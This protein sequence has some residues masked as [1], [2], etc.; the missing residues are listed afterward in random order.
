M[1][2][3]FLNESVSYHVD[4]VML[5]DDEEVS[6]FTDLINDGGQ[7]SWT[8]T[9][10]RLRSKLGSKGKLFGLYNDQDAV[11]VIGIKEAIVDGVT[12]GEIGYLYID[13]DYRS[14][15]NAIK[16]YNI[17][18]D[19]AH[20]FPFLMA[21]TVTSNRQVNT[22]LDKSSKMK[23]LFTIKSPYSSNMLNYWLAYD[24]SG[25]FT[26]DELEEMFHEHF[27][28]SLPS[29]ISGV[30]T[31]S[32]SMQNVSHAP[33]S[34]QKVL[35]QIADRSPLIKIDEYDEGDVRL[36]FGRREGLPTDANTVF[37]GNRFYSKERQ[38]SILRNVVPTVNTFLSADDVEGEF[39]AKR[40]IGQKQDGQLINQRPDNEEDYIFQPLLSINKEYRVV[41]YYMN[42][43]Y[44]VSGVYEKSGSNASFISI[45][46]G[47]VFARASQISI[48]AAKALGYGLS[49]VD[50]ALVE[51]SHHISEEIVGAAASTLG[52]IAGKFSRS[53]VGDNHVLVVLEANTMP[54]MSNP[55]IMHDLMKSILSN[56]R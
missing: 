16:L 4:E 10:D 45:T 23:K 47:E 32:V 18:L 36:M 31:E 19:N 46:G 40:N 54:S 41:V 55:M 22:L 9:P 17:A 7:L 5:H 27:D 2:I 14:L 38:A 35:Y 26:F 51:R 42:G 39:I 50:I 34:F 21:T 43:E 25:S 20:R 53:E 24:S 52:R 48:D 30:V 13:P 44:H 1:R 3:T 28:A 29:T 15:Q 33:A 37:V 12:G 8:L 49:G 56:K 6:T 11:G